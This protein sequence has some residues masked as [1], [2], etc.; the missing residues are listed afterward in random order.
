MIKQVLQPTSDEKTDEVGRDDKAGKQ[1]QPLARIEA[2]CWDGCAVWQP[3]KAV[4]VRIGMFWKENSRKKKTKAGRVPT[5]DA[6][7]H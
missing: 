2:C 3:G 4:S 6:Q 5:H 1:W 7:V